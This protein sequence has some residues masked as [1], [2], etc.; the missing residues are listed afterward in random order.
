M[1]TP[2]DPVSAAGVS[3]ISGT[4]SRVIAA[5]AT[6][7][8][9]ESGVSVGPADRFHESMLCTNLAWPERPT[10]P[11]QVAWRVREASASPPN[12]WA[13]DHWFSFELLVRQL[14]DEDAIS[15]WQLAVWLDY[16]PCIWGCPNRPFE[17]IS[18][19]SFPCRT[20]PFLSSSS[21][22]SSKCPGSISISNYWF[23]FQFI[24]FHSFYNF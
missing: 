6:E 15:Y 4:C 10:K 21:S 14:R 20:F 16:C 1:S 23:N 5:T 12:C 3:A 17:F 18:F 22:S 8:T 13:A 9:Y 19:L 24:F 2:V 11:E 7:V